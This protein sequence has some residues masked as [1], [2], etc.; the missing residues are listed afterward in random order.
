M[1]KVINRI[2]PKYLRD[3]P[4][5]LPYTYPPHYYPIT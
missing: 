5:N 1:V 2:L 4:I 3:T